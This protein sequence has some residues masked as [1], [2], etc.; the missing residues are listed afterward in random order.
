MWPR[1]DSDIQTFPCPHALDPRI[2]RLFPAHLCSPG[3]Q[4]VVGLFF[5]Q[6][7]KSHTF[8]LLPVCQLHPKI[9]EEGEEG[10]APS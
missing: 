9:M 6:I 2:R 10:T 7:Q 4:E 1:K 5:P 8:G 3:L